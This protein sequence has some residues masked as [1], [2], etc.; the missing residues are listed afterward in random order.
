MQHRAAAGAVRGI[1]APE[2][3][4]AEVKAKLLEAIRTGSQGQAVRDVLK[5]LPF[6]EEQLGPE[7]LAA[8][9]DAAHARYVDM[10]EALE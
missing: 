8:S 7:K 6:A 10:V 1:A 9:I 2:G 5:K 4:P 3:L